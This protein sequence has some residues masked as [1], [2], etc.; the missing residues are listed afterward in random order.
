M[1]TVRFLD[2]LRQTAVVFE[3]TLFRHGFVNFLDV[4]LRV[5]VHLKRSRPAMMIQLRFVVRL[6]LYISICVYMHNMYSR[7]VQNMYNIQIK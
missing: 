6:T 4:S 3:Q 5:K 7:N 1:R 2:G